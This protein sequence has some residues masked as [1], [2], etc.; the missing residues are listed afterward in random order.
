MKEQEA[1]VDSDHQLVMYVEREDGTYGPIQTG[2]FMKAN[3]WDD[4]VEHWR[5]VEQDQFAKL[6]AGEISTVGYYMV[7]FNISEADLGAR[8]GVS[9]RKVRKHIQPEHF[10]KMSLSLLRRY[11]EVFNI[12]VANMF[13][14]VAQS[15]SGVIAQ[16]KT[17][18][19]M[20][21]IAKSEGLDRE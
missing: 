9:A 16:E 11:A 2:S 18:N 17:P 15:E 14:V 21:V 10:A 5:K 4:Y 1:R 13:Q 6:R 20:L 12:P 19:P 8:V 3:Y 7:M